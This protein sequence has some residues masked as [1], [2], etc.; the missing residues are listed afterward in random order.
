MFVCI[1]EMTNPYKISRTLLTVIRDFILITFPKEELH[2]GQI[3]LQALLL[4][5]DISLF[6]FIFLLL[7]DATRSDF[8]VWV[9][10]TIPLVRK[11]S[12]VCSMRQFAPL[13]AI[14]TL[15]PALV[16]KLSGK[17]KTFSS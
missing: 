2:D 12:K 3:Y 5:L 1:G 7:R 9:V 8:R 10:F 15:N 6:N 14:I 11:F 13:K 4:C 16:R 17:T